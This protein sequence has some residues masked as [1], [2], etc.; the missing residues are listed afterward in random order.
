M[1]AYE[2]SFLAYK[3]CKDMPITFIEIGSGS[4]IVSLY[5]V[6]QMLKNGC[7]NVFGILTDIS[8]CAVL[9]SRDSAKSNNLDIYLDVVQCDSASCLRSEAARTVLF[10]PPY[11]PVNDYESW[12][13]IAWSG[14]EKG[15]N[16]WSKFFKD[17]IQVCLKGCYMVFVFSSLQDVSAIFTELGKVCID[18]DITSCESFF[19]ETICVAICRLGVKQ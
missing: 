7:Y 17:S 2:A 13:G 9:S 1:L 5:L 19:Y 15:I 12:L 11:L 10:N 3:L 6:K 14:G 4:G 16:I 18:I 8:P